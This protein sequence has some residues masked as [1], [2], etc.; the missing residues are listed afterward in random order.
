MALVF[1]GCRVVVCAFMLRMIFVAHPAATAGASL[2]TGMGGGLGHTI[3]PLAVVFY[4]L[5]LYWMYKIALGI[6]KV[7]GIGQKAAKK[8]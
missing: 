7:L 6:V 1:F 4:L 8:A 2:G 3:A 5:N